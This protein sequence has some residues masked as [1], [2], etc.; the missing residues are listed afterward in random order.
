MHMHAETAT[1]LSGPEQLPR[2]A[3][4]PCKELLACRTAEILRLNTA[5]FQKQAKGL[6]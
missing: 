5:H 4:V 3:A 6:R 1:A 2:D